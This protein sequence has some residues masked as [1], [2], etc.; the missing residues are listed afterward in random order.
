MLISVR[1]CVIQ[2]EQQLTNVRQAA[3]GDGVQS[4]AL[5]DK[6]AELEKEISRFRKENANLES[7]RREREEVRLQYKP[8]FKGRLIR[9]R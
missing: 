8:V 1:L 7:L 9:E 6:L 4:T 2:Q 3:L 5:R